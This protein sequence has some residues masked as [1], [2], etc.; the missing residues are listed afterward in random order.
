MCYVQISLNPL[1][2]IH[3]SVYSLI[4]NPALY[5]AGLR[6]SHP[7]LVFAEQP[8]LVTNFLLGYWGGP[9]L[10]HNMGLVTAAGL[11]QVN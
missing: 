10:V 5:S 9:S 4:Y 7:E 1:P 11:V 8:G 2:S 6:L 3:S